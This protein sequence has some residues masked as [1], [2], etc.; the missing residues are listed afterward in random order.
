MIDAVRIILGKDPL[1]DTEAPPDHGVFNTVP[2]ESIVGSDPL[3]GLAE[4]IGGGR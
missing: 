3:E 4:L 2:D 1:Y